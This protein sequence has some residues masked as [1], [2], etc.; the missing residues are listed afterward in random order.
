M[1]QDSQHYP[2]QE[3]DLPCCPR[4][5]PACLPTQPRPQTEAC[6]LGP[7]FWNGSGGSSFTSSVATTPWSKGSVG[8]HTALSTL[9]TRSQSSAGD[10]E[11]GCH[12]GLTCPILRGPF[13]TKHCARAGGSSRR[14]KEAN[15][16][17][18]SPCLCLM[19]QP[20]SH[21]PA[22]AIV[23]APKN[24]GPQEGTSFCSSSF[25]WGWDPP[26]RLGPSQG[27]K[28]LAGWPVF[29]S[30]PLTGGARAAEKERIRGWEGKEA[31][32][33]GVGPGC[34]GL[35]P[36]GGVGLKREPSRILSQAK[37]LFPGFLRFQK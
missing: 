5:P 35:T 15:R 3:G 20:R 33:G 27:R 11:V 9:V 34:Q 4:P 21:E 36:A 26:H 12:R 13:H 29:R 30:L 22:L 2:F 8:E 17:P 23:D 18:V 6:I 28:M 19:P 1:L 16:S 25:P 37:T 7:I 32:R 31:E 24:Q 14:R 10:R